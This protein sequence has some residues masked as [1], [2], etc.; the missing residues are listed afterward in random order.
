MK[1][2]L[3]L[4]VFL[5]FVSS[6]SYSKTPISFDSEQPP[7]CFCNYVTLSVTGDYFIIDFQYT[8]MWGAYIAIRPID[9]NGNKGI[10]KM[11]L[12]N[13]SNGRVMIPKSHGIHVGSGYHFVQRRTNAHVTRIDGCFS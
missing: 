1:K 4:A 5:L 2:I 9:S 12:I 8:C 13:A 3:S 7:D 6:Y 10:G 11:Y